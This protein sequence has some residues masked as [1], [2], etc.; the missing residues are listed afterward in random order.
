MDARNGLHLFAAA[1]Q[2]D[3][4]FAHHEHSQTELLQDPDIIQALSHVPACFFVATHTAAKRMMRSATKKRQ[5]KMQRKDQRTTKTTIVA[6]RLVTY[7]AR[8]RD[9]PRSRREEPNRT[10]VPATGLQR[11]AT[12]MGY[13]VARN[14]IL[15]LEC[16]Q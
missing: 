15:A 5:R 7:A 9:R 12:I 8:Y 11:S 10:A 1:W 3:I 13:E 16:A 14:F 6:R 2:N 4:S